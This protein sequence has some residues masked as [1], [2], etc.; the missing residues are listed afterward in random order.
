MVDAFG[1]ELNPGDKVIY[2]TGT[3]GNEAGVGL[4]EGR[5]KKVG[6]GK[7]KDRCQIICGCMGKCYRIGWDEK[8][9]I[10]RN[11]EHNYSCSFCPEVVAVPAYYVAKVGDQ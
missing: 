6:T 5:V 10:E 4:I 2:V 7:N 11:L 8:S 3:S 1:S 9:C